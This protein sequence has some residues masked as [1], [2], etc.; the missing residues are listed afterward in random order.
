M[1]S[2]LRYFQSR[3]QDNSLWVMLFTIVVMFR[4]LRSIM[5]IRWQDRIT[6]QEVLDRASSTSIE[7][8][9]LQ[10]QLR[11]TG[12]VIRMDHDRIPRQLFYSELV[13]GNRKQ[14]RP[15][16]RFKDNLKGHLKWADLQPR[17]LESAASDRSHWRALTK[18]AKLNFETDRRQRLA[19]AREK[20]H[21][22]ASIPVP[23]TGVACPTCKRLCASEFGLRSHMRAHKHSR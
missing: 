1:G 21:R 19:A 2:S 22:A 11:W 10:A 12:H 18:K 14:G 20:R 5:Q 7:A 6:N 3:S 8:K 16:K 4:A 15:R 23:T 17:Q 13:R 9:I